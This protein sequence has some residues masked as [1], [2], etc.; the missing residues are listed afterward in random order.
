MGVQDRDYYWKDRKR[1]EKRFN[2]KDTYYRPKEF[3]R[4]GNFS[5][6]HPVR[7]DWSRQKWSVLIAF[8]TG[9]FVTFWT[10]LVI[11]HLN[12]DLLWTPYEATRSALS[13]LGVL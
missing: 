1:R 8:I 4:T 3:R 10:I 13:A 6:K 9:G 2:K 7:R 11:M 5:H 12:A